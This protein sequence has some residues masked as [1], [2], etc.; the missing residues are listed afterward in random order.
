[1]EDQASTSA[2]VPVV[3]ISSRAPAVLSPSAVVAVAEPNVKAAPAAT[4]LV[5]TIEKRLL[6]GLVAALFVALTGFT[7]FAYQSEAAFF[8][9]ILQ[10]A[11]VS[12]T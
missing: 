10:Q 2:P 7:L 4:A 8:E 1:M 11:R 5:S 3:A 9:Q 6:F 12:G